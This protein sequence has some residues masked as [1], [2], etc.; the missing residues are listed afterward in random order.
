MAKKEAKTLLTTG[1][2]RRAEISAFTDALNKH[3]GKDGALMYGHEFS[4][5]FTLRR[6]TGITTLDVALGGGLPAGGLTEIIG[7]DGSSKS[8][9]AN[10]IMA[11]TQRIY[12]DDTA[13]A[14]F[15]TEMHFD[16]KFAKYNCGLRIAYSD[17][18][19]ALGNKARA[20]QGLPPYS[21]K[22]L[23]GLRDSIGIFQE[24]IY[25]SAE[26]LLEAAVR[27]VESNLFQ[28]VLI[29]S[30]GALMTAAEKEAKDG[31]EDKHYGGA[32]GPIT[33]FMHR[34]H[35]ALNLKDARGNMNTTTVIGINQYRDNVGGGMF[36]PAMRISGG[37]ALKHGKLV[38]LHVEGGAKIKIGEEKK[39]VI[40]GKEVRWELLKGKA[41]C[42]DGPKGTYAFY[43]GENGYPFFGANVYDDLLVAGLTSGVLSQDGGWNLSVRD[44]GDKLGRG[45]EA[46]SDF[47]AQNPDKYE[48][49]RTLIFKE[50][51][52]DFIVKEF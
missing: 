2:D 22:E 8:Y 14:V 31:I 13:L 23:E 24:G 51:K 47:L 33:Q 46:A 10:R 42:H 34:L 4:N 44:T 50:K 41:G 27:A 48:E 38:S 15:M 30:F 18:E 20:D 6:P 11:N 49:I 52:L 45:R 16:K 36:A 3:F 29:D 1:F 28:I 40:V 12:G 7:S 39:Q 25:S 17:F 26:S 19:I 37:R 32:S 43:F 9:L 21:E 35:A 5:V